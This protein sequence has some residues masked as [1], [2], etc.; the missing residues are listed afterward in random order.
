[1]ARLSLFSPW[2]SYFLLAWY[3]YGFVDEDLGR[4]MEPGIPFWISVIMGKFVLVSISYLFSEKINNKK[5][6]HENLRKYIV[7]NKGKNWNN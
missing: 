3:S 5:S 1:M 4:G 6:L 2:Y 7:K